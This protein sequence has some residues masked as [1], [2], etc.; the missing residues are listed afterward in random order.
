MMGLALRLLMY[1]SSSAFAAFSWS[2]FTAL[3]TFTEVCLLV[4]LMLFRDADGRDR[5]MRWV[6]IVAN[7]GDRQWHS[8]ST[9]SVTLLGKLLICGSRFALRDA[10]DRALKWL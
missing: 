1:V 9:S 7:E 6:C 5:A 4:D 10:S 2:T 8:I 3:K